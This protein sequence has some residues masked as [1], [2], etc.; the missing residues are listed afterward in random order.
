MNYIFKILLVS[1]FRFSYI[2][3]SYR[4]IEPASR[5]AI[6]ENY[7]EKLPLVSVTWTYYDNPAVFTL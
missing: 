4:N 1:I 6:V 7:S 5:E 2:A 3:G